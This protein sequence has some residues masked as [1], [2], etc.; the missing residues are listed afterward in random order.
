VTGPSED[1]GPVPGPDASPAP[2]S[3]D[4]QQRLVI[5]MAARL[6]LSL[7][8]LVVAL[9][10][11]AT[12][13]DFT[14]TERRG[15][16]GTVA[17]AFLAT[18]VTGLLL[19]RIRRVQRFAAI[20][21]AID[22]LIVSALV[23][24]SGGPDSPFA[25][26]YV[27]VAVYGAALFDRYGALAM[28]GAGALAYG[29]VLVA[30]GG[31]GDGLTA[32]EPPAVRLVIWV[33]H[34]GA[35]VLCAALA[36]FLAA[37]LRRA[38]VEL[39]SLR[40]LYQHTFE[41]LMSGLTTTDLEGRITAF[42]P[43]AERIA[44]VPAQQA[45][46]RDIE[47][48]LPGLRQLVLPDGDRPGSRARM[49]FA[50]ADGK[51]LHLGVAAYILRD[52][53]G[54]PCGHV[55]IFQDVTQVVAME[56]E[57]RRSERMAAVGQ[58]SA[59]LAHEIRNPLAAISG[60]IQMLQS[61]LGGAQGGEPRKLM[62]IALR[63]IDR[64]DRLIADF[65]H[66]ARP[67]SL[68]LVP[69]DVR[70]AVEEVLEVFEG[71]RAPEITVST[72]LQPELRVVADPDQL[73][74]VLWNLVLNAAQAMSEGGRLELRSRA[75]RDEAPQERSGEDRNVSGDGQKA[76]WVEISVSDQ[77][78]GIA[79]DDLDRIFDPFYTTKRGGS[80]LGL[81]TVHRVVGNHGGVVRL[82]SR[83]GKGTTV[84]IRLPRAEESA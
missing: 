22:L 30:S 26:L 48:V 66:Y 65:L 82:E 11:D 54:R 8:S 68:R 9:V 25:F 34:S 1:A 71:S 50:R 61:R 3:G 28:A 77:G 31:G 74:Q 73:R 47:E 60:S 15:F 80:G 21:V 75:V 64:L 59:S 43:E 5:L 76:A 7:V 44:H 63:E 42:N 55:V 84:R 58:L 83:M 62:D 10:L 57:L 4:H 67:G 41:S 33:V 72:A 24:L 14:L 53:E 27:L 6:A 17:L 16:Y 81:A 13:A 56:A 39:E 12:V 49:P 45:V 78:V 52:G 20:S 23:H 29:G 69:V 46:G 2:G 32:A 35:L 38:G 51:E 70:A 40:R 18:A 79:Q 36:S 37:E 19:G